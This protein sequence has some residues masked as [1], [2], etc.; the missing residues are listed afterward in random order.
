MFPFFLSE[1]INLKKNTQFECHGGK[2]S[3][4]FNLKTHEKSKNQNTNKEIKIEIKK[5]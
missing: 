3:R 2:I 4:F 5:I 1:E